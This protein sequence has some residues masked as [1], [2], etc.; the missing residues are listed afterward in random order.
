MGGRMKRFLASVLTLFLALGVGYAI[1][2]SV[3]EQSVTVVKG[4]I[5]S[6]KE[7]FF[8]DPRVIDALRDNSL[9][10]DFVKAGSREIANKYDLKA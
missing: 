10:V 8:R 7:D 4:L 5:G 1:Y 9:K 3:A 2:L 6:E